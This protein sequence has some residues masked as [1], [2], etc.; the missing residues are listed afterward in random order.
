VHHPF[1]IGNGIYLRGIERADL[2]GPMFDW[3][4]DEETTRYLFMGT[5]PNIAENLDDWFEATRKA[6]NEVV[7]MICDVETDE[8]IGFAGLHA[9]HW[10]SRMGEYR[11][12]IGNKD[13]RGQG[14]G[15]QVAKLMVRYAFEKLNLAKVYLGVN[16]EHLWAVGSYEGAGFVR[17]GVLRNEIYRNG[18]YYDAV[19]MSILRDEYFGGLKASYDAD[20]PNPRAGA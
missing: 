19:R 5:T 11:V 16:T 20:I 10:V 2:S 3:A 7:F 13:Y 12:F 14:H 15:K 1:I 17:E 9:I 6:T 4:N 8:S 18:R